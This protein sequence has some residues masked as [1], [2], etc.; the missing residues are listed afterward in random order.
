MFDEKSMSN[1]LCLAD[2]TVSCRETIDANIDDEFYV[3]SSEGV[4][5]HG[6]TSYRMHTV[7]ENASNIV[8]R[9]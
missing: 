4:T 2:V 7:N 9:S 1:I 3:H 5:R 6:G 8:S